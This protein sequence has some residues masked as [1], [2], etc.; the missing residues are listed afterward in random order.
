MH[1]KQRPFPLSVS[2][3][4]QLC[5]V[6]NSYDSYIKQRSSVPVQSMEN[7]MF[8]ILCVSVLFNVNT[9]MH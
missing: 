7:D 1:L 6:I 8:I 2:P 4:N 3:V 9:L 5:G